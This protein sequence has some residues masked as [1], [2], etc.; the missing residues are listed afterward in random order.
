M[1]RQDNSGTVLPSSLPDKPDSSEQPFNP[2]SLLPK[3]HPHNP[4]YTP[5]SGPKT[6][7]PPPMSGSPTHTIEGKSRKP[8][9]IIVVVLLAAVLGG[10]GWYV[11]RAAKPQSAAAPSPTKSAQITPAIAVDPMADW[12]TY[13]SSES[14][15]MLKHP[16]Q[17]SVTVHEEPTANPTTVFT[18][19]GPTQ[20]ENTEFYDGISLQFTAG[21]LGNKTLEE[22]V[23]EKAE[24]VKVHAQITKEV[25]PV[26]VSGINGYGFSAN[27]VG[28]ITYIYLPDGGAYLQ[29]ADATVDPTNLGYA[30][31]VADMLATFT[32]THETEVSLSPPG[33]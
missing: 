3:D 5:P 16:E 11:M 27:G 14:G 32:F 18:L 33:R 24:E 8:F 26:T 12:Q 13:V 19:V 22:F 4:E 29:I 7:E 28:S 6:P 31:T 30:K 17:V 23:K 1:D 25:L 10:V 15:F 2:H 9:L 21:E 20:K